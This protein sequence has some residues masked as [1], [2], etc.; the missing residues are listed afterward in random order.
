MCRLGVPGVVAGSVPSMSSP[1]AVGAGMSAGFGCWVWVLSL[2]AV[3]P[4]SAFWGRC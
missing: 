1:L 4:N 2:G 3:D